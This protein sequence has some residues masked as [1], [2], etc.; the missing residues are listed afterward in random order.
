MN[1]EQRIDLLAE[2]GDYCVSATPAWVEAQ[3]RAETENKWFTMEFID[4]AVHQLA[5]EYLN[6]ENLLAWAEKYRLPDSLPDPPDHRAY[7]GGKY[8]PGGVS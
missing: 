2:L 4:L 7:Y 5:A 1:L 8:P 3:R 6:K